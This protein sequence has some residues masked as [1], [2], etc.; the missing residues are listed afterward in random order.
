MP[1]LLPGIARGSLR[2]VFLKRRIMGG[3]GHLSNDQCLAA[4]KH[5]DARSR[6]THVALLHLSRECNDPELVRRLYARLAPHLIERLTI[7]C[8]KKPSPMLRIETRRPLLPTALPPVPIRPPATS[9]GQPQL[10]L[11]E[12]K[13]V[14][15]SHDPSAPA[16]GR[17][18]G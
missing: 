5:I 3:N 8:Q 16:A 10:L 11:F 15:W 6:L 14:S 9:A 2:P 7:T 1:H 18:A 13:P 12:S 4:V 17:A